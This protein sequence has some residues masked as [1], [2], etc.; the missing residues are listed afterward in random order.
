M[1]AQNGN[2]EDM[3]DIADDAS[4]FLHSATGMTPDEL[5][6][7]RERLSQALDQV[8]GAY[9]VVQE[10]AVEGAKATDKA[11]RNNPYAAIGIAAGL[12]VLVGY[13]ITRRR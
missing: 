8:R 4:T 6:E 3:E 2:K 9:E 10:K 7:A 11:I 13:L 1:N 12:G 5:S